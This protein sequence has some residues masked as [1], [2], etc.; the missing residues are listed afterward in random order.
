MIIDNIGVQKVTGRMTSIWLQQSWEPCR[1][2]DA[3]HATILFNHSVAIH[4]LPATES[5]ALDHAEA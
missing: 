1:S 4:Q 5:C 2:N 3:F